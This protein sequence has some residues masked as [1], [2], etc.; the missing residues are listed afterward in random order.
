MNIRKLN[1]E[2][3]KVLK[4]WM[5]FSNSFAINLSVDEEYMVKVKKLAKKYPNIEELEYILRDRNINFTYSTV[6]DEDSFEAESLDELQQDIEEY[7]SDY[8]SKVDTSLNVYGQVEINDDEIEVADINVSLFDD[9][10]E[11]DDDDEY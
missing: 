8:Y 11:D 7:Y 3:K 6:I 1:E 10:G 4:E 9:E 2:I 5:E